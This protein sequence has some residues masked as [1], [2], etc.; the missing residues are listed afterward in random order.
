MYMV[1]QK[2]KSFYEA[3][4]DT[5][6]TTRE[7]LVQDYLG[8]KGSPLSILNDGVIGAMGVIGQQFK[9]SQIWVAEVLL[10]ARNM[11]SGIEILFQWQ[12]DAKMAVQVVNHEMSLIG[13][14][15][16][17]NVRFGGTP[18]DVY[19]QARYS[20]EAGVGILAPECAIPLE[21]PIGY[22]KPIV[23]AAKEAYSNIS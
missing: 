22:L 12:V 9:A 20:M 23:E 15:D 5:N 6:L 17:K 8:K 21:T 2:V 1:P 18:E 16:N 11:N 4:R 3:L 19:K 14:I 10:A 13:N 7:K